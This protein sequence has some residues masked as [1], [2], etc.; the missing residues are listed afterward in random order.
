MINCTIANSLISILPE[1]RFYKIKVFIYK[2][3]TN[4]KIS[5]S[6][7]M[8]SSFTIL[9]VRNIKIGE[10]TFI[11]YE[12]LI[13]GAEN[14]S[15]TIGSNVDISSRVSIITGTHEIGINTERMAG[16]GIGKDIIIGNGVWIG[17][18]VMIM[19]GV[20]IGEKSIVAAGSVVIK[21]VPSHCMVA[22]NPASIKKRFKD[23]L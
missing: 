6:V 20:T 10:D 3:F 14:S 17:F 7:R 18:G 16:I 8:F 9:G 21:N 2:L 22:G 4:F 1:S 19:P 23:E 5:K 11:G 13:M 12:S 15:V